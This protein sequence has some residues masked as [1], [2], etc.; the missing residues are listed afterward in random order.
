MMVEN[1]VEY[2]PQIDQLTGIPGL[3]EQSVIYILAEIS[4]DMSSFKTSGHL[5]G[6]AGLAPKDN[7]SAGRLRYSKTQKAN[8][9]IKSVMME[10]AW[11]SVRTRN[12]R[13]SNWYWSNVGRLGTKKAITAVARKLLVYI[14]AM[15]KSGEMYDDSLDV[16]DTENRKA[17]KLESARKIVEHR[18]NKSFT[19]KHRK[20]MEQEIPEAAAVAKPTLNSD[21]KASIKTSDE[22]VLPR[23]RGRP[24]KDANKKV[25]KLI[26]YELPVPKKRGRPRKS[27]NVDMQVVGSK[28]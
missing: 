4:T 13:I 5:A 10:C 15:V 27:P 20:N 11:A 14:Y 2:R 25:E 3:G 17:L 22:P 8:I 18:S 6:W 19:Q 12:T 7:K 26:A 23:K 21:I 16:A 1:T 9:Y 28:T 24:R